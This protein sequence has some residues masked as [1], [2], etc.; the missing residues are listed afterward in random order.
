M[1]QNRI[2]SIGAPQNEPKKAHKGPQVGGMY[3][4]KYKARNKPL[5]K[6]FCPLFKEKW[7][8]TTR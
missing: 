1:P 8:K 4:P 6:S 5:T 2:N 7:S 3:G